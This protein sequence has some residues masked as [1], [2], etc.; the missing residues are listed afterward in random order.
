MTDVC[1]GDDDVIS[2]GGNVFMFTR[3]STTASFKFSKSVL[4]SD[5][6]SGDQY[7]RGSLVAMNNYYVMAAMYA[8][9]SRLLLSI[10][11]NV[12]HCFAEGSS[13]GRVSVL[14]KPLVPYA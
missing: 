14:Y 1:A 11:I 2:S 8:D 10:I 5:V 13:S 6:K 7:G 4:P 12:S 9:P 3:V